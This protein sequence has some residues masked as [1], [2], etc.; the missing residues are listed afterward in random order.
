MGCDMNNGVGEE[1]KRN[2]AAHIVIK[3]KLFYNLFFLQNIFSSLG[4]GAFHGTE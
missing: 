3:N 1:S 4:T 2:S